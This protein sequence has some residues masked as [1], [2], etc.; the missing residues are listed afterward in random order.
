M[1]S[2][3][4]ALEAVLAEAF[5]LPAEMFPLERSQGL[6]LAADAVSDTDSPPFDKSLMDGFAIR[7]ADIGDATPAFQVV[8]EVMAGQVPQRNV[9][10]GEAARIMTGAPLPAG[11]D[12]VVPV[13]HTRFDA[14]ERL[15]VVEQAPREAGNAVLLRGSSLR[16]GS[17][18]AGAGTVL[19][20]QEI[21]AL[22]EFGHSRVSVRRRP[23]VAVLATGDELVAAGEQPGPGQIRNTNEPMLAAQ[24]VQAGGEAV[25][26][27]IARDNRV[28]LA[29]HIARGLECDVLLLSGGVSAGVLDLV[30]SELQ[31]AGVREVFHRIP[32]RPGRP[33]WFGVQNAPAADADTQSQSDV[34]NR[35]ARLVFGLPGN[36]VS[37]MVCFELFVRPVLRRMLGDP[38]P[39]PLWLAGTLVAEHAAKGE[40]TTCHPAELRVGPG[41]WEVTP[42]PWIGSADLQAT[43]RA[44]GLAIFPP[45]S[46]TWPAD[47]AVEAVC[48]DVLPAGL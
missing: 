18:V 34:N 16:A 32:L 5:P 19:R 4:A 36:P 26:L 8:E 6:I 21:A 45:G 13:E 7:F 30:P 42:V 41:G 11:A 17:P 35:R 10:P 40:R 28:D 29:A 22:A 39:G 24:I 15:V 48:W 20:P 14:T 31:A 2:I 25:P 38:R 9:G 3:E 27:G 37:S 1:E 23:R 46:R 43:T 47:E 12:T 33:L 44:N